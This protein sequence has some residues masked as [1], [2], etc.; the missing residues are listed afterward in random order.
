MAIARLSGI[1]V[2]NLQNAGAELVHGKAR[3]KDRHTVEV[4]GRGAVTAAK[5]L[6]ATGGHPWSPAELPDT[7]LRLTVSVAK[8]RMPP[9]MKVAELPDRVL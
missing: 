2:R 8:L 5:I 9:P 6:V 1:Y 7:V 4:E 3:L